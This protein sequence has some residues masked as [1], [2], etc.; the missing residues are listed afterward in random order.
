V[1]LTVW[2]ADVKRETAHLPCRPL[3]RSMYVIGPAKPRRLDEPIA[4][5]LEDLVPQDH[6]YRHLETK[7]DLSFVR[8]WVTELYAERGRPSIDPVIYFKLQLIMFFEAIRSERQ[9]IEMAHL[10]LAHRWHLGYA[11]DEALPDHSSLTRI[12]QRSEPLIPRTRGHQSGS[13]LKFF[14]VFPLLERG[15][16][17]K[18]YIGARMLLIRPNPLCRRVIVLLRGPVALRPESFHG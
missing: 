4:V 17:I 16:M 6:F 9:L 14:P 10:N 8:E 3:P 1:Q 18:R 7:V 13:F 12:R 11:L 15:E 5:S 2:S